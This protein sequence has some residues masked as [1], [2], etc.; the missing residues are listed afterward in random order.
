VVPGGWSARSRRAAW[1]VGAELRRR[2]GCVEPP[3]RTVHVTVHTV[4]LINTGATAA[5][6]E[7]SEDAAAALNLVWQTLTFSW[8]TVT[9]KACLW[10]FVDTLVGTQR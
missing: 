6:D 5:A 2:N 10:D 4:R 8:T 1:D 9:R 7:C 3:D